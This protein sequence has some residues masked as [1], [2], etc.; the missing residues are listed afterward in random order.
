[1]GVNSEH[2]MEISWKM[3]NGTQLGDL[4]GVLVVNSEW[5]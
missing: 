4:E 5:V 2:Q 1:M 3:L